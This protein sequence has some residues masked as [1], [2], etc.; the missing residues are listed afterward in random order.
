MYWVYVLI[1][2]KDGNL[3]IGSSSNLKERLKYHNSGKVKSA[4]S[5]RPLTLLY[6]QQH[7]TITSARKREN[8]LKSGQGRKW[9]KDEILKRRG[10]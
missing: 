2:K 5:R 9:L 4:K 6:N 3:Y 1:S 7:E 8:F 10:G